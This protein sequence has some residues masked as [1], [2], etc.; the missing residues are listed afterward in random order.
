MACAT[1]IK[2][3]PRE[4]FPHF[5]NPGSDDV[6]HLLKKACKQAWPNLVVALSQD[7]ITAIA[8]LQGLHDHISL[9]WLKMEMDKE[10]CDQPSRKLS[11]CPFC[12]YSGSNDQFYL[13]HIM[14]MHHCANYGCGKCLDTVFTSRQRLSMHMKK[15][16]G[17][18]MDADPQH[19][20][21]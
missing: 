3:K 15:C 1:F 19:E 4:N 6:H 17:L 20:R 9:Q 2:L 14:C 5:L 16:K 18:T 10:A 13:N 7:A 8:L 12:Q 21:P 11:S